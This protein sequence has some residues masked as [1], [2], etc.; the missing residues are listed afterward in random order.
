MVPVGCKFFIDRIDEYW[1]LSAWGTRYGRSW[2]LHGVAQGA[3]QLLKLVW[4]RAIREGYE[5][6]CP[7]PNLLP[8]EGDAAASAS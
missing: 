5:V 7:W 6:E 2:A 8:S 1:R 3:E 4:A